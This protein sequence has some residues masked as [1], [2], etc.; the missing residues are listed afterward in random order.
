MSE[1]R[2]SRECFNQRMERRRRGKEGE[3]EGGEAVI[4]KREEGRN[5]TCSPSILIKESLAPIPSTI[6]EHS[7]ISFVNCM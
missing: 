4:G 2:G 6:S 1:R 5:V 3:V 7:S